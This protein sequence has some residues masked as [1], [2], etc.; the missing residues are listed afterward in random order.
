MD[1]QPRTPEHGARR[2]HTHAEVGACRIAPLLTS[3][4]NGGITQVDTAAAW[5]GAIDPATLKKNF[6]FDG[7]VW[8]A[9]DIIANGTYHDVHCWVFTPHSFAVL[10]REL[11]KVDLLPFACHHFVDTQYSQLEFYVALQ[12]S[13]DKQRIVDSW[14]EMARMVQ[15]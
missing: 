14:A 4:K 11:A 1:I 10:C 15:R 2:H 5:R 3:S 12:S 8:L 9:R 13:R 6:T 7:A